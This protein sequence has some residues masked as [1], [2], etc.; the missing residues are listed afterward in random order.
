MHIYMRT[1]TH[2]KNKTSKNADVNLDSWVLRSLLSFTTCHD[3]VVQSRYKII[4]SKFS[5]EF[6]ERKVL[7]S[8][9]DVA[10]DV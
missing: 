10:P 1:H 2:T 3:L 9:A 4:S 5:V 8:Q 6:P 7:S